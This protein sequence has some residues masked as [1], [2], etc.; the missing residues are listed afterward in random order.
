MSDEG[1]RKSEA[2]ALATGLFQECPLVAE[3][4]AGFVRPQLDRQL[5]QD[6]CGAVLYGQL[7]R[8]QGW[9]QTLRKL[10]EPSDFQAVAAACRSL[11][12]TTIDMALLHAAPTRVPLIL[13]WEESTRLKY[14]EA[15]ARYFEE[16]GG[17]PS[18]GYEGYVRFAKSQ[19]SRIDA[20]RTSLAWTDK[21]S[22]RPKHPDRWTNQNL[23]QD[24]RD[25]DR[26]GH[27]FQFR[28][29][30]E[31]EYRQICWM[32][33]GAGFVHRRVPALDF[34]ALAGLLFPPCASLATLAAEI[35]VRHL[36][37]WSKA[38][39]EAFA[40]LRTRRVLASGIAMRLAD[41]KA[42]LPDIPE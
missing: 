2:V 12:E 5:P 27:D 3:F 14:A 38:Q 11:F 6:D 32:V 40:S 9:L 21:K 39:E 36:A 20:L 22:H 28:A 33:H 37:G 10:D 15:M 31:T 8:C 30:Y 1:V 18:P 24:A 16:V 25:A 19:K 13:A 34:P 4:I 29:F 17:P 23:D 35:A 42:P 41:G 26:C 7:L